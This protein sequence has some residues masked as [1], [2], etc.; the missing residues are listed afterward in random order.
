MALIFNVVLFS[1]PPSLRQ[2]LNELRASNAQPLGVLTSEGESPTDVFKPP[3]PSRRRAVGPGTVSAFALGCAH[4]G[5]SSGSTYGQ[6]SCCASRSALKALK[7]SV[8]FLEH[9]AGLAPSHRLSRDQVFLNTFK[10]LLATRV[11][12]T[13]P[14]P[15]SR[16]IVTLLITLHV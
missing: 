12:G 11:Q 2:T 9:V 15:A 14:R 8:S 10:E 1:L 13:R 7:A 6:G 4:G 5:N 16:T 3:Y